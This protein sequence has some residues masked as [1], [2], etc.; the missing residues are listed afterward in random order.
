MR[1]ATALLLACQTVT[2]ASH[3]VTAPRVSSRPRLCSSSCSP[4][5]L[6][7][8]A[9]RSLEEPAQETTKPTAVAD[10]SGSLSLA[11]TCIGAVLIWIGLATLFYAHRER[12]PYGQAFFCVWAGPQQHRRPR[13]RTLS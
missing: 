13:C 11:A 4:L 6:R 2:V 9:A 1:L 5:L 3:D 12:W 8:G 10:P 7:G